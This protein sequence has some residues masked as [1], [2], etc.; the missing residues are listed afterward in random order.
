MD[1]FKCSSHSIAF[2]LLKYADGLSVNKLYLFRGT[3]TC[4]IYNIMKNPII[5]LGCC[6]FFLSE[7]EMQAYVAI[8][9]VINTQN[10]D[11][12]SEDLIINNEFK[13][14]DCQSQWNDRGTRL[15][16]ETMLQY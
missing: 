3:K 5:V 7:H 15:R 4:W 1:A 13:C 6:F 8:I 12:L 2:F 10:E 9:S 11:I 16:L 14:S